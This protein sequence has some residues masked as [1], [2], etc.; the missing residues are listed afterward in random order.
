VSRNS[1]VKEPFRPGGAAS[2]SPR[3]ADRAIGPRKKV[4]FINYINILLSDAGCFLPGQLAFWPKKPER[5]GDLRLDQNMLLI[6]S[7]NRKFLPDACRAKWCRSSPGSLSAGRAG[8]CIA[9]N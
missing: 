4:D 3:Q 8:G 6:Y 2:F 1:G 7:D 9:W 5:I